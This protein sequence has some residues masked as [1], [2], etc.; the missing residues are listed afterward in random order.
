MKKKIDFLIIIQSKKSGSKEVYKPHLWYYEYLLFHTDQETARNTVTNIID[1]TSSNEVSNI[2]LYF[3]I[4]MY[5]YLFINI[6]LQILY[7]K[8]LNKIMVPE[9]WSLIIKV[10]RK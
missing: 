2:F 4:Y 6:C 8:L 1:E 9:Y 3:F 10:S 7:N 5:F